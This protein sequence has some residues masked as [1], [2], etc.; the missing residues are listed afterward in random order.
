MANVRVW[1][2]TDNVDSPLT[3]S[4]VDWIEFSQGND[5][6]IFSNG[7]TDVADGQ[8]LPTQSELVSAGIVLTGS[9][10]V[11]DDYFMADI[12]A[13]LIREIFL[14]GNT[15]NQYVMAFD[16]D[17][18]TASEPVLEIWDDD[19][20][21]TVDSIL[22]GSGTPSASFV[23][24]ITTTYSAPSTNWVGTTMAGSTAGNFLYLNDE[25]G[26]LS[27][28]DTLYANIKVIIPASQTAGF[29]ANPVFVVKWLST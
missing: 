4:G 26:P 6:L 17:G 2:N 15:T 10:I 23:K 12:S 28:A 9:E 16:F 8:N 27:V 5:Y 3:T 20:L 29:S 18:S 19:Q 24:G 11:V 14:M 21:N 7:S 1:I 25:N 13:N 22:L